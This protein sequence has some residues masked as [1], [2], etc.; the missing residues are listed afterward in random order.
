MTGTLMHFC[1]YC[2]GNTKYETDFIG[3]PSPHH[4]IGAKVGKSNVGGVS[5][6][7]NAV[8]IFKPFGLTQAHMPHDHWRVWKIAMT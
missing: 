8:L 6:F 5:A 2:M 4:P 7:S 3:T 1:T